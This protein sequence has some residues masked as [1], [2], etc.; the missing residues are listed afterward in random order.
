MTTVPL[1]VVG[2]DVPRVLDDWYVLASSRELRKKPLARELY[3]APIVLFR[4]E[5][6]RAAALVDRCPHRS[7]PLS[8]GR[9]E[10]GTLECPYHG[11]RFAGDG[12]CVR[13]PGLTEEP[14]H[15]TRRCAS[16]P[17]REQDGWVWVWATA[18][19]T[20]T[21]E[22]FR[23]PLLDDPRY[24]S[25][26]QTLEMA[27]TVHAAA[28]NAL[29]VPHTAFLHRGLFRGA[30]KTNELEVRVRRHHDRVEAEYIGEPRPSGALGRVLAPRGGVVEHF[31]RFI[32]PSITQVEY[33]L[34][35]S[36]VLA[37]VALT[38]RTDR[39]TVM[40][41]V[42]SFRLPFVPPRLA[43]LAGELLRPLGLSVLR[44]DATILARQDE[45][46]ARFGEARFVSTELDALGPTIAKLLR[47][48]ARGRE[49]ASDAID[50][51]TFRM[52]V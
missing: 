24:A 7:V 50:E 47:A 35:E 9:V 28:E 29:D 27:G 16:Y 38:P 17:V 49:A 21:R 2:P 25:V 41:A 44:Q 52:R 10:D 6:G 48:A 12:R 5:H 15:R 34:G 13:V 37:T 4:D 3:G 39:R 43:G 19:D 11:W 33:R 46:I 30:G 20:P 23:F 1:R 8:G 26:R 18:G 22:P 51:R 42:V 32:L 31:D 45:A 40:N 14:D 36:H